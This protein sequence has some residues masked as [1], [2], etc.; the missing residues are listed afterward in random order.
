MCVFPQLL[1]S[2]QGLNQLGDF[3]EPSRLFGRYV[4][5]LANDVV[6]NDMDVQGK[7]SPWMEG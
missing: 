3:A 6:V 1:D 7:S 5:W 2:Y 4:N